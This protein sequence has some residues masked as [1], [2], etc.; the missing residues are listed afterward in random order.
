MDCKTDEEDNKWTQKSIM[1]GAG[2]GIVQLCIVY[3]ILACSGRMFLVP[4]RNDKTSSRKWFSYFCR[5]TQRCNKRFEIYS[6]HSNTY[7]NVYS[8]INFR[9]PYHILEMWPQDYDKDSESSSNLEE[10]KKRVEDQ[11]RVRNR[12]SSQ[13]KAFNSHRKKSYT[14]QS[15]M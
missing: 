10:D 2:W 1:Y 4:S 9:S 15:A 13:L 3:S 6:A 8:N 5:G 11:R 14:T 7:R 12:R